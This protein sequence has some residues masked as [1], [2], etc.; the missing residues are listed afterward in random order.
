MAVEEQ[1]VA[2]DRL[3]LRSPYVAPG[4]STE[5]ELAEIWRTVLNMD[6]VGIED[7]YTDLG[8]DSFLAVI[9]FELIG[10]KFSVA[11]PTA[12][13]VSA[14]TIAAL[15]RVIA[16]VTAG[17]TARVTDRADTGSS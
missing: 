11:I 14:P 6:R 17:V 7:H 13:L 8:G 5:R 3:M 4:T 9:M 16:R 1:R 2:R 15:A 12:T 10:R